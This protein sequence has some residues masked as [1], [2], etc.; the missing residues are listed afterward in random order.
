MSI[1]W[2]SKSGIRSVVENRLERMY[3]LGQK[4]TTAPTKKEK[5]RLGAQI[6]EIVDFVREIMITERSARYET[7]VEQWWPGV[8]NQRYV[9]VLD[10]GLSRQ[11]I[12]RLAREQFLARQ[13]K[14]SG[15]ITAEELEQ[16]L[17][18]LWDSYL[19]SPKTDEYLTQSRRAMIMEG[20][21]ELA[22]PEDADWLAEKRR[23]AEEHHNRL[24]EIFTGT[25]VTQ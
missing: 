21:A 14:R 6:T 25:G 19:T 12:L 2:K 8:T 20:H 22:R 15:G 9:G 23:E 4:Q 5:E 17:E 13:A 11:D 16:S 24:M 1:T 7:Q 10:D 3:V 18:E